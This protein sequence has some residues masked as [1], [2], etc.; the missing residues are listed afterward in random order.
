MQPTAQTKIIELFFEFSRHLKGSMSVKSQFADL[1]MLQMQALIFITTHPNSTMSEIA[2][3]F[4]IEL[5]SATS[6]V[7][8]LYKTGL[9]E[10]KNDKDDRRKIYVVL[11]EKGVQLLKEGKK[12]RKQ[13][14]EKILSYLSEAEK[15]QMQ[16]ILEKICRSMEVQH[17]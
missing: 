1:S 3:H 11:T 6:L 13:Q 8:K 12:I 9:V 14:I 15:K 7:N 17:E 5:P 4:S 10:R 2:K 16:S